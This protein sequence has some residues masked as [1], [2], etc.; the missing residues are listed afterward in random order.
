MAYQARLFAWMGA[1]AGRIGA[2]ARVAATAVLE[3]LN[4]PRPRLIAVH[5]QPRRGDLG[6]RHLRRV[7]GGDLVEEG[8]QRLEGRAWFTQQG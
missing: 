8:L 1:I 6:E 7:D 3:Q 4:P 5:Q 2:P